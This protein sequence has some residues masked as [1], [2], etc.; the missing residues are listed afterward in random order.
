MPIYEF[1]CQ[2]CRKKV[3]IFQRSM[4]TAVAAKC[5]ECGSTDL[6]RLISKFSFHRSMP[7]FDDMSGLDDMMDG[8]DENDP[9]SVARWARR[10]GETMGEDLP[11]DF[12]EEIRRMEAGEMPDDDL[13]G[14]DDFDDFED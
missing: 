5:P 2:G 9:K 12:D 13:G 8:L 3:S 14:G 1:A 6:S 4:T 7:D 11:P 10:M